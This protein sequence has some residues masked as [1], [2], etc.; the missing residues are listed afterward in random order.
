MDEKRGYFMEKENVPT[1]LI[2]LGG[3]GSTIANN[4]YGSIPEERR[5]RVAIHAFDTDVN[6]IRKLAHLK[7]NVTQTSTNRSV[8]EYLHQND[9]LL[10]WFP[11]NPYLRKK[12]MTEGAGQIRAVSRLAFRAAMADG[13]MNALWESI[14]NIF[15]VQKDRA[16]YGVR[17]IIIS[18]LVGGTGSGIYLQVAMYLREMLERKLGQSSVLIRGAFLLP[19]ILVRSQAL[20]QREWESVQANGYASLKELNAITR[21]ASATEGKDVTIELEYR[22]NQVDLEG[23]TTHAITDKQ[24]PYDFCFLYDYEN[25]K[26]EHLL[27]VSDYIDQVSQTIYLQLFSPISAKHFS[28]EDNQIL[29]LIS[30]E[31]RGRFCGAGAASLKYPYEDIL[32]YSALRWAVSGLDESWL[33]IDQ[34]YED[35]L[36][37]YELDLRKGINRKKLD[38]GER[39]TATFDQLV[40]DE[41]PQPFFKEVEGHVREVL[42]NGKRGQLKTNLFISAMEERVKQVIKSDPELQAQSD[43]CVIDEGQLKLKEKVK[44]EI[45]RVEAALAFYTDQ[46]NKKVYEYRTFLHH[47]IVDQDY[48]NPAGGEGQGYRLNTWF[49]MK[50]D[51]VHPLGVRYMLYKIHKALK[52]RIETL[53]ESNTQMKK[54]MERYE[55]IYN[56]SDTEEVED[57]VRRMELALKQHFLS[58][59]LN[60]EYKEFTKEYVEKAG[61]QH[62]MLR[63]YSE[64][65]LLELVFVSVNQSINGM[66]RDWERFFENLKDTRNTLLS[67]INQRANKFE[68]GV[69]P[70][71]EYVLATK[72][73]Q[74]KLWE[75]LRQEINSGSLPN[76]ISK[77][78][79]LSHY[80]QYCERSNARYGSGYYNE[81]KVEELY[82][83]QVLAHCRRELRDS[84]GDRLDLDIIQALRKEAV[85]QEKNPEKHIENRIG[86]LAHLSSPF[87]PFIPEHRELKFWGI[88]NESA[89]RMSE[90]QLFECFND[91]EVTDH[92]FS[93]HEVI[94]YRA[95][96][97]LSVENFQKFS[98]GEESPNHQQLP[99]V[100]FEAYRKRIGRL[101]RGEATVTPHLDK[102]WHLPAYMPDLNPSHARLEVSKADRAFLLGIIYKWIQLVN[103]EGRKVYQYHGTKGSRLIFQSGVVISDELYS[104]HQA[105]PHNPV[106]YDE[107]LQRVQEKQA[108]DLK[109]YKDMMTHDFMK[110]CLEVTSIQKDHLHNILDIGLLYESEAPGDES[111]PEIG[112]RIRLVL[113]DEIELYFM[114]LYGEHRRFKARNEAADFIEKLWNEA[115]A[116]CTVEEDSADYSSWH[117]MIQNKLSFLKQEEVRNN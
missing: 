5:E 48:D 74:G 82:R 108:Y 72:E 106:I 97:G 79:Y 73:F 61:R 9:S 87:I 78:L 30:S 32:E 109:K 113:L 100:Y 21:I 88:H 36:K 45:G 93:R 85:F 12:T 39:F 84:K 23:R 80:R 115:Q 70:T 101:I 6:S 105:L 77:E 62:T 28:L 58:S 57:A 75:S 31:G 112:K 90:Q 94:C 20:D 15:P 53:R 50:P 4:I 56:L 102:N 104:L 92:A 66:I 1:I 35:E 16:T 37:R 116:K 43:Q 52:E 42:S 81:M 103:E 68:G 33:M 114:K 71:R 27:G 69:N 51:P 95:H 2:G 7:E 29:E 59:V 41:N 60:N 96:Y 111:L 40:N 63:K 22:P 98:A 89:A 38:R 49:L 10:S 64:S 14:E 34:I 8:G 67:E 13:K 11:Q 76:S 47:Q 110:G 24:L 18:S 55:T 44:R 83:D 91:K 19:D 65:L 25:L 46:I 86:H 26:G 107:I 54:Q 3:I 17:V 99:G 117:N